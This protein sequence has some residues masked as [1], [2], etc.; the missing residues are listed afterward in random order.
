MD[1]HNKTDGKDKMVA[2][3]GIGFQ[4]YAA[5]TVVYAKTKS[6]HKFWP[7]GWLPRR[8]RVS[9]DLLVG[10]VWDGQCTQ[11]DSDNIVYHKQRYGWTV[12][13]KREFW[14]QLVKTRN[15]VVHSAHAAFHN[16]IQGNYFLTF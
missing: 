4:L 11:S 9:V 15:Q 1:I 16:G 7:I 5:G 10:Q 14:G 8:S 2:I 13:K 12:T 3:V 6:Y